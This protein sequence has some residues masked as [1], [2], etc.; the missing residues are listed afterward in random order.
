MSSPEISVIIAALNEEKY[1]PKCLAALDRQQSPPSFEVIVVDNGS[2]DKT[3][4]IAEKW[5]A[6]VVHEKIRG[7]GPAKAKGAEVAKG[8]ILAFL[9][10]DIVIPTNWLKKIKIHL[11]QK[12][13]VGVAGPYRLRH[14]VSYQNTFSAF[15][16]LLIMKSTHLLCGGSMAFS[17]KAYEKVG[18]FTK[19]LLYGE[20]IDISL[21]LR[22]IGR[23]KPSWDLRVIESGRR[24]E[25]Q[26]YLET[27]HEYLPYTISG[28]LG[29]NRFLHR[30]KLK[31][32]R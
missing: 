2:T 19:E 31:N 18:G 23:L 17:K 20:D 16:H 25:Q 26:G 10:A 28:L 3:T 11:E 22:K 13:I 21:K 7:I 27:I 14:L 12:N 4:S 6:R 1:L 29:T 15:C 30:L 5:G 8:K 24:Y 32:Y 9:D